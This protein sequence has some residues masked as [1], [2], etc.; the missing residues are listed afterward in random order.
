MCSFTFYVYTNFMVRSR[1]CEWSGNAV[2]WLIGLYI[3]DLEVGYNKFAVWFV[4]VPSYLLA[5]VLRK[6]AVV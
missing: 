3:I 1:S 4:V 5:F 2:Q 6:G